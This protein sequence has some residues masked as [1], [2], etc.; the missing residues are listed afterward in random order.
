MFR[1]NNSSVVTASPVPKE[2]HAIQKRANRVFLFS[3]HVPGR[4]LKQIRLENY[5]YL[6]SVKLHCRGQ[7]QS[8]FDCV[9]KEV[10]GCSS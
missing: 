3:V 5:H 2:K 4:K 6:K 8:A 7:A 10:L 1:V 9:C